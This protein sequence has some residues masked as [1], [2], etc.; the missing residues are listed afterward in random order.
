MWTEKGKGYISANA[1][2]YIAH[3]GDALDPSDPMHSQ[4]D[5]KRYAQL[6]QAARDAKDWTL[7]DKLRNLYTS[8]GVLIE[9]GKDW[10]KATDG[11]LAKHPWHY[12]SGVVDLN[13]PCGKE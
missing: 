13:D 6:V 3:S 1:A 11:Y 2:S 4:T 7:A 10:T 12:F 8:M 5:V 9:Q